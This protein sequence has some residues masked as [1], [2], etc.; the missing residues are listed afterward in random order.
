MSATSMSMCNCKQVAITGIMEVAPSDG[1]QTIYE[2]AMLRGK[3]STSI[4]GSKNAQVRRLDLIKD[5]ALEKIM[6][7]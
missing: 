7:H 6:P 3:P 1:D 2:V 5:M 4:F